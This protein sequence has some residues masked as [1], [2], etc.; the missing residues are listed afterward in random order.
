LPAGKF[1]L[2]PDSEFPVTIRTRSVGNSTYAYIVN[3]SA[4]PTTLDLKIEL[5]AGSQIYELTG[6]RRLPALLADRWQ[7]QL[8]PFD[9]VAVRFSSPSAKIVRAQ[10]LPNPDLQAYLRQRTLDFKQGVIAL[11]SPQQLNVL[12]NPNFE[13]SMSSGQIPGWSLVNPRAGGGFTLAPEGPAGGKPPGKQ[14]ITLRS[15]GPK[16]ML[17]SNS[18][19]IP[20]S[21]RVTVK[22]WLKVPDAKQQPPVQLVVE[23]NDGYR[24]SGPIGLF[25]SDDENKIPEGWKWFAFAVNDLP[26]DGSRQLRFGLDLHG[27][28][29]VSMDNVE[30]VDFH[31][32]TDERI[33]LNTMV[34][35]ASG[36]LNDREY[37]KCL[38]ELDK[39]WPRFIIS[40]VQQPGIAQVPNLPNEQPA[41]AAG[42]IEKLFKRQ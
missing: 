29:E 8:E 4:W 15:D 14:A 11:E 39:F 21:R 25:A 7:L 32:D 5:P 23:D 24:V 30:I 26:N 36:N 37:G 12:A 18:F 41:R 1:E 31:F 6:R 10:T 34:I 17:R 9:L 3:D 28:G 33:Q 27:A 19:E 20:R 2:H 40:C 13:T 22:L 42:P 38:R 16:V 35:I